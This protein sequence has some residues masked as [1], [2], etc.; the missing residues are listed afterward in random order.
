MRASSWTSEGGV[1]KQLTLEQHHRGA[2]RPEKHEERRRECR[3]EHAGAVQFR[4]QRAALQRVRY[5][6]QLC[7][8]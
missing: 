3:L 2:I 5:T 4:Q 6:A 1:L 8:T 7:K